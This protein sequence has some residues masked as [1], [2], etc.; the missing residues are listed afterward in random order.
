MDK[1]KSIIVIY[2]KWRDD[3]EIIAL[4]PEIPSDVFGWY[5]ESYMHL[6]QHSRADYNGVIRATVPGIAGGIQRPPQ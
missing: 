4:F 6:G 1:P 5:C 2:R 3:A